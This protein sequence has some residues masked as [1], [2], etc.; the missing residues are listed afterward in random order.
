VSRAEWLLPEVWLHLRRPCLVEGSRVDQNSCGASIG[1]YTL[2]PISH[3]VLECAAY[4]LH[5]CA[6]CHVPAVYD[7]ADRGRVTAKLRRIGEA[8]RRNKRL[9]NPRISI[10]PRARIPIIK[11]RPC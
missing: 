9:D 8:L 5:V 2:A 6:S 4:D 7:V 1:K 11:V 10:I 3:C